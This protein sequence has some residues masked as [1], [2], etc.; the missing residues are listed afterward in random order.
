MSVCIISSGMDEENYGIQ[1]VEH[2]DVSHA[3]GP[4]GITICAS[5]CW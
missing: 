1:Y 4:A 2:V 5:K 3:G